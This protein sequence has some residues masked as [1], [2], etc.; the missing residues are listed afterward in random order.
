MINR[1][2]AEGLGTRIGCPILTNV[3]CLNEAP[4]LKD[5]LGHEMALYFCDIS[6]RWPGWFKISKF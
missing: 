3:W 2:L 1:D 6:G 4:Y 5:D